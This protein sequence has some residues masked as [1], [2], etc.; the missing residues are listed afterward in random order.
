MEN[1]DYSLVP[2]SFMHCIHASCVHANDCLR[3]RVMQH[4]TS[5]R[6]SLSIVNPARIPGNGN[7]CRH[8]LADKKVQFA[9]GITHLLNNVPY[10]KAL[11]IKR[12]LKSYLERS[13][14]YRIRNKERL[15][16]PEEQNYIRQLFLRKGI[17]EEPVFDA[18]IEQYEW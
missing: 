10:N 18:Y 14:Y 17:N 13:T 6:E 11:E 9:L 5:D 1:F 12:E 15:I 3:Y 4:A 16:K 8:F 7:K 2:Y